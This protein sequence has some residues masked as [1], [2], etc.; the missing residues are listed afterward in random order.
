MGESEDTVQRPL[1]NVW[2]KLLFLLRRALGIMRSGHKKK[3]PLSRF[4]KPFSDLA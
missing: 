2:K 4:S 1:S 3:R